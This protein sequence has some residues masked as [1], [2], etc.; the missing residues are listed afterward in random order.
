MVH[1]RFILCAFLTLFAAGNA[2]ADSQHVRS[3][4]LHVDLEKDGTAKVYER[5]DVAT[6]DNI[7]EW[8]LVPGSMCGRGSFAFRGR[9]ERGP[10]PGGKSG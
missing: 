10:Y 4:K 2:A 3:L 6:G 5:W 9:M 1:I 7:T 8:Y